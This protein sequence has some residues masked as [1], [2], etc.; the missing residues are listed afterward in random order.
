VSALQKCDENGDDVSSTLTLEEDGSSHFQNT[1][2]RHNKHHLKIVL[3]LNHRCDSEV[4]AT[5]VL[6]RSEQAL[7]NLLFKGQVYPST[8]EC[9]SMLNLEKI[10]GY[11]NTPEDVCTGE[12]TGCEVTPEDGK[13]QEINVTT[14]VFDPSVD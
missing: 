12:D 8:G 14:H 7:L 2:G 13:G 11:K 9:G 3:A 10:P 5:C 6:H 1:L 4:D